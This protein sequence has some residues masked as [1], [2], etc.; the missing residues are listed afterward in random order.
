M[1]VSDY[2]PQDMLRLLQEKPAAPNFLYSTLVREETTHNKTEISIDKVFGSQFLARY[3]SRQSSGSYLGK[4]GF[5][6]TAYVTPYVQ[7]KVAYT[8]SDT[9]IRLPGSTVYDTVNF[10]AGF[11]EKSMADLESR[12]NRLNEQQIATALQTGK[13]TVSGLDVEY[14]IDYGQD[15]THIIAAVDVDW[16]DLVVTPSPVSNIMAFQRLITQKG[17]SGS[18]RLICG[19]NAN[20]WLMKST[21]LLNFLDNRRVEL[22]EINP[23]QLATVGAS[24]TGRL[25]LPEGIVDMY[26]YNATY[27]TIDE[28]DG[29]IIKGSNYIDPWKVV[30]VSY[31]A[32]LRFHYGMIENFNCPGFIGKRFPSDWIEQGGKKRAISM[33]SSPLFGFHQTN[34][35]VCATVG[36]DAE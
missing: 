31:G 2:R 9:Q 13:L 30:F 18:G 36:E 19:Y 27:D 8:P 5:S 16:N 20:Y 26:S 3:C 32:D 4:K 6:N 21:E 17:L 12:F 25:T 24:Y 15:P 28:S 35:V 10:E 23:A 34:A 22:G 11:I 29:S 33:E 1:A 7:E 14:E